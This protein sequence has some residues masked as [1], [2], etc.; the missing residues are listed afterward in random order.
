MAINLSVRADIIDIRRYA[1][2]EGDVFLVDTNVWLWMTHSLLSSTPKAYQVS[3]YP[4]FAKKALESKASL[5]RLD[6][7]FPELANCIERDEYEIYNSI[8][9]CNTNKFRHNYSKE[10]LYIVN[11]VNSSWSQVRNMSSS[12]EF[13]LCPNVVE[14]AVQ[15]FTNYPLGG[16]DLFFIEALKENQMTGILTDDMDFACYPG[17]K[18]FTANNRVVSAARSQKKLKVN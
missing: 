15:T 5:K 1:P 8:N 12:V 18:V 9:K 3:R 11:Q 7:S 13:T 4:G 6:L 14:S 10:R 16:Y 17:I 2:R